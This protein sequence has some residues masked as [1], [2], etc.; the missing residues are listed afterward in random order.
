MQGKKDLFVSWFPSFNNQ[1]HLKTVRI[2]EALVCES[3]NA[4]IP[5]RKTVVRAR[6]ILF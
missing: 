5:L 4:N 2:S 1:L 3:A 6:L